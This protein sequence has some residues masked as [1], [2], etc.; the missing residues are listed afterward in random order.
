MDRVLP[1]L[2]ILHF[3]QIATSGEEAQ[4]PQRNI[5]LAIIISLSLVFMAYFGVSSALTLMVPYY[6]QDATA[7]LPYAFHETGWTFAG[8]IG[9]EHAFHAGG[10]ENLKKYRQINQFHEKLFLNIYYFP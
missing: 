6:L 4:N 5:P 1:R 2:I 9:K 7:P 3:F 8:Y 10:P